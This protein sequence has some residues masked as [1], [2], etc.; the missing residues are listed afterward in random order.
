MLMRLAHSFSSPGNHVVL[1]T[2]IVPHVVGD[3]EDVPLHVA[4]IEIAGGIVLGDG[5]E[6]SLRIAVGNVQE[7][8]EGTVRAEGGGRRVGGLLSALHAGQGAVFLIIGP[9]VF[10]HG[11]AGLNNQLFQA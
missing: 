1:E 6:Q 8:L 11:L 3:V 7:I 2:E 4:E 10:T 9:L 5:L